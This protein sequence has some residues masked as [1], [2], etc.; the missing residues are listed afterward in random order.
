MALRKKES[1]AAWVAWSL[2][3]AVFVGMLGVFALEFVNGVNIITAGLPLIWLASAVVGALV[4]SRQPRNVVGWFFLGSA[5]FATLN[6][7]LGQ[8]ALYGI[9]TSPGSPLAGTAAWVSIA[10]GMPGP[11]IAFVLIPLYFPNGRAPSRRW[12]V[13]VW[14]LLAFLPPI[15]VLDVL[16]PGVAVYGT[17]VRNPLAIAALAPYVDAFQTALIG[18]FIVLIFVAAASLVFRFRNSSGI[19][20]QQIKWLTLAAATIPVWFTINAP[21]EENFR[22]LFAIVDSLIIAGIPVAAGIAI[23]RY[24]LYEIDFIINKTLVYGTLTASLVAVYFGMVVGSQY[25]FRSLTGEDSQIAIVASTLAIAAL[26]TPFRRF[27][28]NFTD[29]RFYRKRYDARETLASFSARLRDET[30]LDDLTGDLVSIVEKTMQPE[31]ASLWMRPPEGS[32]GRQ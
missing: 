20:R 11:L 23:L 12:G 7:L 22:T 21:I 30:D 25:L 3:A 29:R 16:S 19:E 18:W 31:H 26:F 5:F 8:Y 24:R 15:M 10:V 2:C 6:V 14:S 1:R 17:N 32:E 27:L 9:E 4:V 13:F 28:Q